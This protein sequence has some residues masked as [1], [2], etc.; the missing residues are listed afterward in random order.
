MDIKQFQNLYGILYFDLS[1]QDP[2]LLPATTGLEF[3]F[4][5][6]NAPNA[7]YHIYALVLN[8]E[9]ITVDVVKEKAIIRSNKA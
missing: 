3:H 7:D 1:Y 2:G 5:L 8:E 4:A 9:D 6:N